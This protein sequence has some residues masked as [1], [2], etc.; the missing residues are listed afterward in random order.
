M[1]ELL[2]KNKL[3]HQDIAAEMGILKQTLSRMLKSP[4]I[5]TDNLQR[6]MQATSIPC[7]EIL[8]QEPPEKKEVS[9]AYL[10]IIEAQD[11]LIS[12]QERLSEYETRLSKKKE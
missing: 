6:F 2:H 11:K 10:K 5:T 9:D 4:S 1:K 3:V 8:E 12:L 7:W